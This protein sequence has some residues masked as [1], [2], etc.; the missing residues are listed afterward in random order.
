LQAPLKNEF[1]ALG[2]FAFVLFFSFL[3]W[4]GVSEIEA[5]GPAMSRQYDLHAKESNRR[6][7]KTP[8]TTADPPKRGYT[9]G[10]SSDFILHI[11]VTRVLSS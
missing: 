3:G 7:M 10:S 9:S 1:F 2:R 5:F 6:P 8:T 11:L 4:E